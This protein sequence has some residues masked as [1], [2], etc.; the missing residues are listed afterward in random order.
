VARRLSFVHLSGP[1]RGAVDD[2]PLPANVGSDEESPVKVPGIAPSH[3]R[4]FERDGDVVLR[5]GGS[6]AGTLLAGEPV[7][8]AVLRDGDVLELGS[9]GPKIRLRDEM[10]KKR[11][12]LGKA[13]AWARPE[14]SPHL[15]DAGF[16]AR[17][18]LHETHLRT[19]PLFRWAV[20]LVLAAGAVVLGWS[21]WQASLMRAELLRLRQDIQLAEQERL[22]FYKRIDEQRLKADRD[23]SA[24]ESQV[25]DL[26]QREGALKAQLGEAAAGQVAAVRQDLAQTRLRLQN[27]ESERA[28]GERI[29]REYGPGVSLI[30]GSYAFYDKSSR[31]LR[32]RLD[33]DERIERDESGNP[34]LDHAGTGRVHI[35][36]Y[37]GTGFLVDNKKGLLLT[38]RHVAEP[39]WN[40]S[41]AQ[42]Q[43]DKGYSP[44]FTSFRAF[45]PQ[46][47]EPFELEVERL[48]ETTDLAVVRIE[49]RGNKIPV[50]PLDRSGTGAVAGHPVVVVG[51]PAGL[52]A[53]LAKQDSTVVKDLLA[54]S[55]TSTERVTEALSKKGL[56]RPSTTQGHIGD[57]T[58][59]DIVFDAPTT[60]GG[61]GGPILN[62]NG[63][64]IAVEYAVLSKFGGNSFG[65]PIHYALDLLKPPKP[66]K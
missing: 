48:S 24:L 63:E 26:R 66:S 47:T 58:K 18:L 65:V 49:T 7:H 19:S 35:V 56:I 3:C 39:W 42:L 14:G 34:V 2:V 28:V 61:S 37:F 23:R 27:L 33:D 30:Q 5:D 32:Y 38:N 8:E 64:V 62:R 17:A 1:R 52:E 21:Q 15:S 51:Y 55:G 43:V 31:P 11:I 59:S 12:P 4:V 50:L 13:L 57:I 41:S 16:L 25:E 6:E 10:E 44:R 54:G 20:F 22:L 46:E 36:E 40:D 45:F 29:I 60:Q 53:I 9:G